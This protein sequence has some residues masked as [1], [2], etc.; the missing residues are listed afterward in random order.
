MAII[1]TPKD[2]C[3][4]NVDIAIW[5]IT[6]SEQQLTNLCQIKGIDANIMNG[7]KL[8][9]RRIEMLCEHLL[10]EHLTSQVCLLQHTCTGAPVLQSQKHGNISISHTKQ[11]VAVAISTHHIGIDIERQTPQVLR[12]RNKFLTE[13]EKEALPATD[14]AA[15]VTA[16][17]AK[18]AMYKAINVPGIDFSH[19]ITIDA[20]AIASGCRNYQCR[21]GQRVFSAH[22]HQADD[23]VATLVTEYK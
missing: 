22:T 7:A 5:H 21:Y 3:S 14:I 2:I 1:D 4:E 8:E 18:E 19:Q 23:Y 10:I 13:S 6:E 20:S 17:T 11:Y 16:W 9:K 12:V 15:N